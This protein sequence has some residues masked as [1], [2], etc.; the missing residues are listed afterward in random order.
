MKKICSIVFF[1]LLFSACGKEKNTEKVKEQ[2]IKYSNYVVSKTSIKYQS[3]VSIEL[4]N[5][6]TIN[7]FIDIFNEIM[8]QNKGFENYFVR[9][10]L[11]RIGRYNKI[12]LFMIEKIKGSDIN[13]VPLWENMIYDKELKIPDNYNKKF[14]F[15]KYSDV[16]FKIGENR[17]EL[18]IKNGESLFKNKDE[19]SSYI[20][21][22]ENNEILA[23]AILKYKNEILD[24][25]NLVTFPGSTIPEENKK[26]IKYF[27]GDKDI[28]VPQFFS[29]GNINLT[30]IKFLEELNN[31]KKTHGEV[32]FDVKTLPIINVD[33][34]N[35]I[36]YQ[37]NKIFTKGYITEDKINKIEVEAT[38]EKTD[39]KYNK[40][41]EE[42]RIA[43][44]LSGNNAKTFNEVLNE[45]DFNYDLYESDKLFSKAIIKGKYKFYLNKNKD[46]FIFGIQNN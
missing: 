11:E 40:M 33:G 18:E 42:F 38:G 28:S 13:I 35:I 5:G 10:V 34:Q 30:P 44:L 29:I 1:I 12:N 14:G 27:L 26:I 45:L 31:I 19:E 37:E 9:I 7:A 24:N 20:V 8:K 32:D 17:K 21:Y 16:D 23:E 43:Y 3:E 39:E 25:I 36:V 46:S 15:I 4:K 6:Y 41:M 2:Q 22:N